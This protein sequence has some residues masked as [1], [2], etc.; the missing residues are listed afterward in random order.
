MRTRYDRNDY[1]DCWFSEMLAAMIAIQVGKNMLH[2]DVVPAEVQQVYRWFKPRSILESLCGQGKLRGRAVNG[3]D[4]DSPNRRVFRLAMGF[5]GEVESDVR[6]VRPIQESRGRSKV[7]HRRQERDGA[8]NGDIESMKLRLRGE[9]ESKLT[10]NALE[11][12][13]SIPERALCSLLPRI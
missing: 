13:C 5:E 8:V 10:F 12:H 11:H 4:I 3:G 1:L 6:G 9:I 2:E 7:L